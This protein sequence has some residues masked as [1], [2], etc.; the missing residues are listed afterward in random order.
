[1]ELLPHHQAL[2][3]NLARSVLC[4]ALAG[5]PAPEETASAPGQDS[6][7]PS[8]DPSPLLPFEL[9]ALLLSDPC[10]ASPAGCFVSLHT[11]QTHRLRGCVGRL[12]AD[13]MLF[14]AVRAASLNVLA[15]PRFTGCPVC[16]EELD[17]LEV[18]LSVVSPLRRVDDPLEF[19]PLEH[20]IYLTIGKH[21][22]CF[23]PQVARQT[24]WS[25]QQLLDRL[26]TE[27]IGLAPDAWRS[28]KAA[29]SIFR[30][31]VIGPEP[32]VRR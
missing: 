20:G 19:E 13:R 27:K 1:M 28:A 31:L 9:D 25:R 29:L 30:T 23:L 11:Q 24:G 4:R 5:E 8:D 14:D 16:Y 32:V 12:E 21:A 10:L 3:L 17:E 6:L 26:C 18:E 2:L 7:F 22:G 15:D